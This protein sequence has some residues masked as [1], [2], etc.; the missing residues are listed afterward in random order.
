MSKDLTL[1]TLSTEYTEEKSS[2]NLPDWS[3]I[4]KDHLNKSKEALETDP[5]L[6]PEAYENIDKARDAKGYSCLMWAIVNKHDGLAMYLMSKY[7]ALIN[8]RR[9]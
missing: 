7:P 3:A 9:S 1:S 2:S 5:L 6:A 4:F 8:Q